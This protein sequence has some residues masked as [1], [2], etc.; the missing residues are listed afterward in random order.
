MLSFSFARKNEAWRP[1]VKKRISYKVRN[2]G[3]YNKSL[4]N[5]GNLTLWIDEASIDSWMAAKASSKREHPFLYSNSCILLILTLR[6]Y[7]SLTLRSSQGFM[8]GL[9]SLMSI[10]LPVPD[11][12]C[13]SRRAKH[14]FSI[15]VLLLLE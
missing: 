2:W 11:Y 12:S 3:E 5:R 13:L 10:C 15:S 9:F 6:S 7:F 8:K 4:V 14:R 1:T